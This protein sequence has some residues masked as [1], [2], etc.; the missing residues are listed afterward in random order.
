MNCLKRYFL[1][2]ATLLLFFTTATGFSQSM[3]QGEATEEIRE[4]ASETTEMWSLELGLTT[5]QELLMEK[6]L[7]EMAIKRAELLNSPLPE[8]TKKENLY[9][10]QIEERKDMRDILTEPQHERYLFLIEKRM[11]L[12]EE[13][14]EN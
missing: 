10:L 5:K 13:K 8:E 6:K 3:F 14:E 12:L 7:I 4:R 9:A 11:E 2:L 1:P